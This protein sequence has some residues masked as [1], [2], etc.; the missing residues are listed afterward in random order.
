MNELAFAD[1]V[2]KTLAMKY[3]L[4]KGNG[5]KQNYSDGE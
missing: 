3:F 4:T 1:T 5:R 2:C